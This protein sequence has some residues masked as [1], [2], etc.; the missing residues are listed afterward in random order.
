LITCEQSTGIAEPHAGADCSEPNTLLS[1]ATISGGSKQP[2]SFDA[3]GDLVASPVNRR[4]IVVLLCG[5]LLCAVF[6]GVIQ[7]IPSFD[8][9]PKSSGPT[10]GN[11]PEQMFEHIIQAPLPPS[12][13]NL[14]GFG[15]TWQ[16]YSIF[17][18]FHASP[19]FIAT[20]LAS[21]WR[22]T[23]WQRIEERFRLPSPS[24][25]RFTPP[26]TPNAITPKECYEGQFPNSWGTGTHYLLL[27]RASGILYFYGIAA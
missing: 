2:L 1:T 25:D 12:V 26:W 22:P 4:L 14:Q 17:L 18:R 11:T 13:T 8:S 9:S 15:D 7:L 10:S 6:Y 20:F 24:Y 3:F 19:E 16:G 21:G 27:D 5:V 23:E